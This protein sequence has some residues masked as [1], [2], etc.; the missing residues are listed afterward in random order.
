M[1]VLLFV[2][3]TFLCII[4]IVCFL[5]VF[6]P[7]KILRCGA[8]DLSEKYQRI[9]SF[10]NC[11]AG[12]VFLGTCFVQLIPYTEHQLSYVFFNYGVNSSYT[13]AVTQVLVILGFFVILVV[14][15]LVRVCQNSDD[16][17]HDHDHLANSHPSE[18]IKISPD[19]MSS[20]FENSETTS[21]DEN[22]KSQILNSTKNANSFYMSTERIPEV[23]VA[24]EPCESQVRD[25]P[26]NLA[27]VP[28]SPHVEGHGHSHLADVIKQEFGLRCMLLMIALS[29]HSLFEGIALGLQNDLHKTVSLF[30]GII[31]HEILVSFAM[32]LSL[33]KQNLQLSTF[34]KMCVFYSA[35]IPVGMAIGMAFHGINSLSMQLTSAIIQGIAAG[36]FVYVTFLEILPAEINSAKN[37]LLKVGFI[38][39]GFAFMAGLKFSFKGKDDN[40]VANISQLNNDH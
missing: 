36:T 9:L 8:Q 16:H 18:L 38:F 33:A 23:N 31:M 3:V 11:F 40:E 20:D 12:G 10:C 25:L 32:G 39:L 34:A 29:F 5:C 1:G 26:P 37:R 21:N 24:V 28:G 7:K 4:F 13:A 17:D 2:Q 35:T 22:E 6:L 19:P 14:E 27:L 30:I 15:Q